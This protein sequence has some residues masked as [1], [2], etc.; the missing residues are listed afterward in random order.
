[1]GNFSVESLG[2]RR[3]ASLIGFI[4][5]LLDEDGWGVLNDF[6]PTLEFSSNNLNS[7]K[8]SS[9]NT[10]QVKC[11]FDRSKTSKQYD[12]SIEGRMH[13]VWAKM[14]PELLQPKGDDGQP[15]GKL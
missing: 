1:M 10:T 11:K 15:V 3:D 2:S 7:T 14:P 12:R 6:I 8:Y 13:E 4:L 5:K 9:K